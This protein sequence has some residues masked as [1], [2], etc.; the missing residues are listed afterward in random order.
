[1]MDGRVKT[2]HPKIHGGILGRRGTDDAVMAQHGIEAIDLVVVN[3]YPFEATV[4]RPD[5]TAELAVENIDIGGPAMIRSAAKNHA[6][7]LVIVDPNDYEEV[8]V[9]RSRPAAPTSSCGI[10]SPPKRSRT[11][12]VT[13]RRSRHICRAPTAS[14]RTCSICSSTKRETMRYGENP[15]QRAALYVDRGAALDRYRR[16]R[17]ATAGQGAVVQ[18]RGRHRR[19]ARVRAGLR[20][21]GVRHR[22][23]R[24]SVRRC[25]RQR[26]CARPIEGAYATDPTSA[27]GGIIAFNRPLDA[28]T[29]EAIVGKQFVEVVIAP[30]ID[31][32]A[33]EVAKRRKNVRLLACGALVQA[34]RAATS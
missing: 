27:Y 17:A 1:M 24:E 28:A 7:V 34:A 4:A 25:D 10:G 32:G 26:I 18:Q 30:E 5:V 12:R 2:L 6:D 8:R 19:R 23:A 14:S 31:A 21:A 13:T 15:H 9:A 11:R 22:Q 29:L 20:R 3:L 33:V 16:R